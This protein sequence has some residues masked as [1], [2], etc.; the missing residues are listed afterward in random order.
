MYNIY[1]S[2]IDFVIKYMLIKKMNIFIRNLK[3]TVKLFIS[4]TFKR[5]YYLRAYRRTQASSAGYAIPK[6]IAPLIILVSL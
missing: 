3:M 5:L 4:Y 1:F 2:K 6:I